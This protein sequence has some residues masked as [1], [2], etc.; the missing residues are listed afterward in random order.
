MPD[1][2]DILDF[3]EL[4]SKNDKQKFS[5][6]EFIENNKKIL[7]LLF[8]GLSFLGLGV[9]LF[10]N[11]I[12][13]ESDKLEVLTDASQGKS[14]IVVEISGSVEKPGVYRFTEGSRV[15]DLLVASGGV[16]VDADRDWVA[17]YLNK[18]SKLS[19][20]QKIFIPEV[21]QQSDVLSANNLSGEDGSVTTDVVSGQ[22]LININTASV[23]L[24]ESLNGIG[25]V[26]AQN[27]IEQRPYSNTEELDSKKVIPHHV[28]EKIKD[29]VT[30]Y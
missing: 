14:E 2:P 3:E 25:P 26:Y 6:E 12:L 22:R 4:E 23:S 27:I 19:D 16:S 5:V 17:K 13:G 28:Y 9:I 7:I 1:E 8:I 21:G 18:A 10:K 29:G 20:G 11:G 30:V 24:L 15:E